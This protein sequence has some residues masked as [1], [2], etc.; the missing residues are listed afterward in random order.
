M[1]FLG[2]ALAFAGQAQEQGHP[3]GQLQRERP[4]LQGRQEPHG[5]VADWATDNL[6]MVSASP[7]QIREVLAK[8]P[9]LMVELKRLMAKQAIEKGQIVA[10]QDL[11]DDA[12]LDRLSNRHTFSSPGHTPL[13]ALRL[14]VTAT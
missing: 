9:G 3:E 6:D 10:E 12:I 5:L 2:S 7:T 8:D 4:Q 13:A 14:P 11:L 1:I